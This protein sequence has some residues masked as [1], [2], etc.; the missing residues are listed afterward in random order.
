MVGVFVGF[1]A[2]LLLSL[3]SFGVVY[4]VPSDYDQL[5]TKVDTVYDMVF[6][7]MCTTS[8][9]SGENVLICQNLPTNVTSMSTPMSLVGNS[10][11]Q[12]SL[13]LRGID[14]IAICSDYTNSATCQS[15][16]LD[17]YTSIRIEV[18][19]MDQLTTY[20]VSKPN[21]I[22][23]VDTIAYLS[24]SNCSTADAFIDGGTYWT[25]NGDCFPV[26]MNIPVMVFCAT[27]SK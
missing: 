23:G 25:L 24:Y 26:N 17:D 10:S 19:P 18:I 7:K 11:T 15:F 21:C 9:V 20:Q 8:T 5:R 13:N 12:V 1:F 3:F 6:R 4:V 14:R 16:R 27:W 2:T 22:S